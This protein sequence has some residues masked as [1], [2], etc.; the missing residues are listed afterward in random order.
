LIFFPNEGT[1]VVNPGKTPRRKINSA[2]AQEEKK[3]GFEKR[4][5]DYFVGV[6]K[7][8]QWRWAVRS[9]KGCLPRKD[10]GKHTVPRGKSGA[11]AGE[12]Q[13]TAVREKRKR[14]EGG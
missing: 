11:R 10:H 8:V 12:A 1:C 7:L 5:K 4:S 6:L 13:S 2:M 9:A 14:E 3:K